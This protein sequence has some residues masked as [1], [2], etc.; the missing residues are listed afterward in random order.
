[1]HQILMHKKC[2]LDIEKEKRPKNLPS[3]EQAK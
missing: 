1:M 2:F 3:H